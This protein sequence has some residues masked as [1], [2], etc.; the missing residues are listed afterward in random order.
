MAVI[1]SDHGKL[2]LIGEP[3]SG[4][5]AAFDIIPGGRV[6]VGRPNHASRNM[7]T[8]AYLPSRAV[9]RMHAIITMEEDGVSLSCVKFC[10]NDWMTVFDAPCV[11][12]VYL[13]HTKAT[14]LTWRAVDS[15]WAP[16]RPG[17]RTLLQHT[18]T[19]CF[20]MAPKTRNHVNK[21]RFLPNI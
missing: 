12:K 17:D 9:S 4:W 13:T 15:V 6:M 10:L 21:V 3:G 11:R 1:V 19:L 8:V 16:M 18:D 20:G 7:S 14:N 2:I 5:R